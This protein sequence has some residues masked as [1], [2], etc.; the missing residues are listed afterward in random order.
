M[1]RCSNRLAERAG[2]RAAMLRALDCS[3]LE[4]MGRRARDAA[5]RFNADEVAADAVAEIY[6]PAAGVA[7]EP[8]AATSPALPRSEP[9]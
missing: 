9:A 1:P 6:R 7:H 2:A 3:D 4:A 5:Q 8:A